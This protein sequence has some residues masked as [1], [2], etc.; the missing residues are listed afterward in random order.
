MKAVFKRTGPEI[1]GGKRGRKGALI[2]ACAVLLALGFVLA[3]L[4][5]GTGQH[6]PDNEGEDDG[7]APALQHELKGE[8]AATPDAE[9]GADSGD[10]A[11]NDAQ[12]TSSSPTGSPG[13]EGN[14]S[15]ALATSP[16]EADSGSAPPPAPSGG[17]NPEGGGSYEEDRKWVEDIER[18]W[19]VDKTAWTETVPVYESV[20]ISIC[21][22]CGADITG[23]TSAHNKQHMLAGEESGYHSEVRQAKVGEKVVEHPEEGHWEDVV[24]GGHW[25]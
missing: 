3:I 17:G 8:G 14:P 12:A 5:A 21:N 20:E 2:A 4:L 16:S 18:V 7:Q 11:D 6:P 24:V 25:E 13:A 15:E 9:I 22:V 19:V 1:E 23:N 10:A